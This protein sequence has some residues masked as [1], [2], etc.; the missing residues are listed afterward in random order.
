MAGE[1]PR[2]SETT[3]GR[4]ASA[5]QLRDPAEASLGLRSTTSS[6]PLKE[7]VQDAVV[8]VRGVHP[9]AEEERQQHR[10][11]QQRPDPPAPV[12]GRAAPRLTESSGGYF[13]MGRGTHAMT[14]AT[15]WGQAEPR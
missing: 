3:V 8:P 4:S 1:S 14:L 15:S 13:R 9:M 7:V 11:H 12:P 2:I 5:S 6:D 10:Q